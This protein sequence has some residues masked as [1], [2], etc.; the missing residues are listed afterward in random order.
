MPIDSE[1]AFEA[2]WDEDGFQIPKDVLFTEYYVAERAWL[3]CEARHAAQVRE[4]NHQVAEGSRCIADYAEREAELKRQLSMTTRI[5]AAREE[6]VKALVADAKSALRT[7]LRSHA[8]EVIEALA[9]LDGGG[10]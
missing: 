1:K 10:E 6:K 5:N 9:A 8:M 2:W 4:L 7:R 3:A